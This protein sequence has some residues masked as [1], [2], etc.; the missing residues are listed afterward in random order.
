MFVHQ[1]ADRVVDVELVA[2]AL[3]Y[4]GDLATHVGAFSKAVVP[5]IGPLVS[6]QEIFKER[7]PS[8]LLL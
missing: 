5:L 8:D 7:R 2:V 4:A 3:M 6:A 1:L